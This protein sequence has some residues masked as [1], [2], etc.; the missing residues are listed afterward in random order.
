MGKLA[1]SLEAVKK[2]RLFLCLELR[3]EQML[4]VSY[5]DKPKADKGGTD[6]FCTLLLRHGGGTESSWLRLLI[7]MIGKEMGVHLFMFPR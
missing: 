1:I 5:V 2:H 4:F 6:D 7:A 3:V